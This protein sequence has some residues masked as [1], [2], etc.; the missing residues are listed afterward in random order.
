VEAGVE[1]HL[2]PVRVEP[3]DEV[4]SVGNDWDA[5][6]TG[7]LAPF[8]QLVNVFGDI[9]F[10]VLTAVFTEPILDQFA[11]GSSRRSVNLDVGHETL[12]V[13]CQSRMLVWTRNQSGVS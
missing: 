12:R 4:F 8:P 2:H 3:D 10:F 9:C 1:K 5:D 6:A 7:Q 13:D 11:V